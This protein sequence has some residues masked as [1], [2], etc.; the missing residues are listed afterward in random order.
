MVADL[1]F[2]RR[3]LV[4]SVAVAAALVVSATP[5][6]ASAL[7][8]ELGI[9]G[10]PLLRTSTD[11]GKTYGAFAGISFS[12]SVPLHFDVYYSHQEFVLSARTNEGTIRR[13]DIDVIGGRFRVQIPAS[14]RL[15]P[16]GAIG[17]GYAHISYPGVVTQPST[18]ISNGPTQRVIQR[19]GGFAEL[20]VGLGL[21]I[22]V[23]KALRV[24]IEGMFRPGF[25]FGGDAYKNQAIPAEKK[26]TLGGSLTAGISVVF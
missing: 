7:G 23:A 22:R 1:V 8:G 24:N 18:N 6:T 16:Y 20:P 10:G 4:A 15:F 11:L 19:T 12:D 26:V 13:P 3:S 21:G 17:L 25:A 5:R 14:S 9:N 2:A